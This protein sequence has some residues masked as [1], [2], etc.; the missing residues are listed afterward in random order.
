MGGAQRPRTTDGIPILIAKPAPSQKEGGVVWVRSAFKAT[1]SLPDHES[2]DG[3][4]IYLVV[5]K[6][7]SVLVRDGVVHEDVMKRFGINQ[8]GCGAARDGALILSGVSATGGTQEVVHLDDTTGT[9]NRSTRPELGQIAMRID[10]NGNEKRIAV[11]R[12]FGHHDACKAWLA[13]DG[14]FALGMFGIV[15]F[16]GTSFNKRERGLSWY[17]GR[18]VMGKVGGPRFCFRSCNATEK[19]ETHPDTARLIA[20]LNTPNRSEWIAMDDWI[21]GATSG[22]A[23]RMRVGG[24][25]EVLSGIPGS[26]MINGLVDLAFTK[27]GDLVI[28]LDYRFR[29]YVVWPAGQATATP[30]R[31]LAKGE[32]IADA[33]PTLLVRG[34]ASPIP[35]STARAIVLGKDIGVGAGGPTSDRPQLQR[36]PEAHRK[37][38]ERTKRVLQGTLVGAH[39]AVVD[40]TCGA[41]VRS[42]VGWEGMTFSHG[43][44]GVIPPLDRAAVVKPKS[45]LPLS[46]VSVVPGDP[47]LVLGI[48]KGE[49]HAAWMLPQLPDPHAPGYAPGPG[50]LPTPPSGTDW[51]R[52]GP[53]TAVHGI[54]AIPEP[55]GNVEVGHHTWQLGGGAVLTVGG[56]TV[57]LTR[58]GAVTLPPNTRPMAMGAEGALHA[59]GAL[60][61]K[62][63][64]CR[65]TCRILAP[66]PQADIVAVVPRTHAQLVLGYADGRIGIYTPP[67]TGGRVMPQHAIVSKLNAFLSTRTIRW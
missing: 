50:P 41:Y 47:A 32:V 17:A 35:P 38:F 55:G 30:P 6:D 23:V 20:A 15:T 59:F 31:E 56:D 62:L 22:R 13:P 3:E 10:A 2:T 29:R 60:G 18:T 8:G 37:R 12:E 26:A 40:T 5:D 16:D 48:H 52:I 34:L 53:V 45:C 36:G 21:A 14:R 54:D 11:P 9:R 58:H 19:E 28:G 27:G 43:T 4:S 67:A 46:Q 7:S 39:E 25:V 57:L 1:H 49:L 66:G 61:N 44:P 64:E 24:D 33:S 65:A 63:V 51:T 42:P